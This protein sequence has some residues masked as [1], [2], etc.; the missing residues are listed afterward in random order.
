[1]WCFC[2]VSWKNNICHCARYGW[3]STKQKPARET[4]SNFFLP[5]VDAAEHPE[6]HA[7]D[8]RH[9]HGQQRGQQAVKDEFDQLKGGVASD[10]H[11]V[12]AVRGDGLRDDI[13]KTNLS[14]RTSHGTQWAVK[15][16]SSDSRKVCGGDGLTRRRRLP[17]IHAA[18]YQSHSVLHENNEVTLLRNWR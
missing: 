18:D 15:I 9:G 5:D 13:F 7:E 2:T 4:E 12:E 11:S 3:K 14:D 16:M 17:G 6:D 8:E 10:P 1:M